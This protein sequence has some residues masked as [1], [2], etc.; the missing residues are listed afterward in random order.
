MEDLLSAVDA[1]SVTAVTGLDLSAAF[2]TI[3]HIKLRNILFIDFGVTD[4]A[5]C[6]PLCVPLQS[7]TVR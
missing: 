7:I 4:T 1:S 6:V 2:D 3:S 5:L